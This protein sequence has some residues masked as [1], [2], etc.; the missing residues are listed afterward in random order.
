MLD[1]EFNA[2]LDQLRDH[3]EVAGTGPVP[4]VHENRKIDLSGHHVDGRVHSPLGRWSGPDL[5]P[6]LVIDLPCSRNQQAVRPYMLSSSCCARQRAIMEPARNSC[7]HRHLALENLALRHQIAVYR[8]TVRRPK[9][10]AT[11][12][13]VWV[14]LARVWTLWKHSLVIVKPDTVLRWQRRRFREYWARLSGPA[15]RRP[16]ARLRRDPLSRHAD[17]HG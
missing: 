7:G 1:A 10:R 17:G 15:F 13:L 5:A 6:S 14:G 3:A 16:A 11:D 12:Q 2:V 9:L 4:R 8:R